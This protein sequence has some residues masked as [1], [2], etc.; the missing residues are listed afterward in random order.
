MNSISYRR[1]ANFLALFTIVASADGRRLNFWSDRRPLVWVAA[2][3]ASLVLGSGVAWAQPFVIDDWSTTQNVETPAE[4]GATDT[5][6]ANIS[7]SGSVGGH[8]KVWVE[9]TLDPNNFRMRSQVSAATRIASHSEDSGV[10]GFQVLI[11]DGSSATPTG[12]DDLVA[13]GLGIDLRSGCPAGA[14]QAISFTVTGAQENPVQITLDVF[15]SATSWSR[16]QTTNPAGTGT[17]QS[18][19][20]RFDNDFSQGPGASAAANFADVGAVRL[21]LDPQGDSTQFDIITPIVACGIDY[22]DAPQSTFSQLLYTTTAARK[23]DFSGEGLKNN[24]QRGPH[25]S[26]GGPWFPD[27]AILLGATLV[28]DTD[29]D[30]D[31]QPNLGAN[32]DDNASSDDEKGVFLPR[33]PQGDTQIDP[34]LGPV[35]CDGLE[36][37]PS[38]YCASVRVANPLAVESQVVGWIDFER[39]GVFDTNCSTTNGAVVTSTSGISPISGCERSAAQVRIGN[40]GLGDL[41]GTCSASGLKLGDTLGGLDFSTGN[42]PANCEGVVVLVWDLS[43]ATAVTTNSTYSRFR[44]TSDR[45]RGF[46]GSSGTITDA[47]TSPAPFQ[48]QADGEI[49]DH[50]VDAGTLPVSIHRFESSFTPEGLTIEWGTVSET[51]N[52]GFYLW[53]DLGD[54]PELLLESPIQSRAVDSVSSQSYSVT[55]P[56]LSLGAV[57]DLIITAVDTEGKEEVFGLFEPGGKYG[58]KSDPVPIAWSSVRQEIAARMAEHASR[59]PAVD[60]R[61]DADVKRAGDAGTVVTAVD[62]RVSSAGMQNVTWQDLHDAGL[63]LTGISVDRIAVTLDGKPVARHAVARD[64]FSRERALKPAAPDSGPSSTEFGPGGSIRFWGI[65]PQGEDALYLSDYVYRISVDPQLAIASRAV[66]IAPKPGSEFHLQRV[67]VNEDRG[68]SFTSPLSDP[69]YAARL[70]AGSSND[71]YTQSIEVDDWVLN[72]RPSRLDIVLAG[73]NNSP[74]SPN[75][76]VRILVNGQPIEDVFFTGAIEQQLSF[77]VPAGLIQA[78]SNAITVALPGGTDAQFDLVEV[79]RIALSYPRRLQAVSDRLLVERALDDGGVTA[80]GFQ[81]LDTVAYAWNG[82]LLSVLER[83]QFSRGSVSVPTVTDRDASYWISATREMHRPAVIAGVGANELLDGIA[84]DL[85]I[86]AHPAFIPLDSNEPH[87]LNDYIADRIAAGWNPVVFDVT[88][89]QTHFG[90]GMAL[91]G[92]VTRF[93]SVA[94]SSFEFEHV[95]LVGSDSYDYKD[96]LGLGSISFIPTVYASTRFI[97][98]TPSD[99]L[100]ADLDGDGLADKAVGRWPVR[101]ISDLQA[102]VD[103]TLAWSAGQV[104]ERSAIWVA[105]TDDLNVPSFRGQANR[106][107]GVLGDAGWPDASLDRIFLDD[108]E[109]LAGMSI[110]DTARI[111]FFDKLLQGRS[112][113]GFSGHGAP[114]MWTF[115]GL[116]TP[117]DL[118]DLYNEGRPTLI[119]TMT[120]YTSYFVSPFNDTVAHRWMNGYRVDASGNQIPGVPNGA[121]AIHGAATLSNY[122][123]NEVFASEV[124][125]N[126][127]DG[128]T[129]GQ[130]V[131]RARQEA[132]SKN[133]E[134]LVIN[135]TLLGDPTLRVGVSP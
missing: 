47:P 6:A 44:I 84:G 59:Q 93:L 51:R 130:A 113:T 81:S 109:P 35:S 83:T 58:R 28:N 114:T 120:C 45:L 42:V 128:L 50:I 46:F 1:S 97:S 40:T 14:P 41:G 106:M 107:L 118:N 29:R 32:G 34:D 89:I 2:V 48:Y 63:D 39:N 131:E 65:K 98:Y 101:G 112:L 56:G 85:V 64:R 119:G 92:A 76:H 73:A 23:P 121:V 127:L 52:A 110:A 9:E 77:E 104:D 54:G 43:Q 8:R 62:V 135:W 82:E 96:N 111:Q 38:E 4:G 122:A 103:K 69:W 117:T 26:I 74:T 25:H 75:H 30:V 19:T 72:D 100:L 16:A 11:W 79:D 17:A 88:E 33:M 90:R 94:A 5:A 134:D 87:P 22:G 7:S 10:A 68:Y 71:Q 115:Q 15:T 67:I 60:T 57:R 91:P 49:E 61:V 70:R 13:D 20:F 86:I 37:G 126:Q 36:V 80:H 99:A 12:P 95:L 129:L 31:G 27:I 3:F 133:I 21:R 24:T 18:V 102:T 105:D 116:L 124:L 55:I 53:G 78:G 66:D 108:I 132:R 123:Q 125:S